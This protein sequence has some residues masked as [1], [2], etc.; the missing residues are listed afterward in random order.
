MQKRSRK[1]KTSLHLVGRIRRLRRI[2]QSCVDAKCAA[3]KQ[4]IRNDV[5]IPSV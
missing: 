3:L 5:L 4:R 2:R 1:A